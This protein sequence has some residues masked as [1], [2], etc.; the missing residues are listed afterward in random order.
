[1]SAPIT[2][3]RVG[4]TVL[5]GLNALDGAGEAMAAAA[6]GDAAQGP[7]VVVADRALVASGLVGSV[8]DRTGVRARVVA[9]TEADANPAPEAVEQAATAARAAGAEVVLGIGGGSGLGA[10][11]AVAVLLTNPPPVLAYEGTDRVLLRPAP[12]IAVP[13]TAGSGSEV[14]NA[15]V[16]HDLTRPREVVVRGDGYE[17]VLAVLDG[18]LLRGLPREPLLHAALD[19]LSHALEALWARRGSSITDGL[20]LEAG[21]TICATLPTLVAG[22]TDGTSAAGVNDAGLQRI[23]EASTM[24]N[25]ACGNSGLALVHALSSAP[26]VHLPHGLQ[27]AILLPW[28]ARFNAA[29]LSPAAAELVAA[30]DALYTEL[31]FVPRFPAGSADAAAM[32]AASSGHVFRA[33]NR[34]TSSD[35]DIMAVLGAAGAEGVTT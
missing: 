20:A 27:N 31:G 14:S 13:T 10:A 19:A 15:L 32:L 22:A 23:L 4:T 25:L 24:A 35:E 7:I 11:K 17:P 5:A 1:M 34:R 12:M 29:E 18:T 33:N 26:S 6:L 9:V 28:V 16:L 21:R 2:R 30:T 3:F 8:L